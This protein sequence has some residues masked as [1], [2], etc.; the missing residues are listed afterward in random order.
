M[1]QT[2]STPEENHAL[3]FVCELNRA[4]IGSTADLN[5]VF[6]GNS[7]ASKCMDAWMHLIGRAYL[8][9]VLCPVLSEVCDELCVALGGGGSPHRPTWGCAGGRVPVGLD[10]WLLSV[11]RSQKKKK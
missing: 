4:E 8:H 9:D 1:T 10:G 3:R 11:P 7:L 5:T 6:R 2:L